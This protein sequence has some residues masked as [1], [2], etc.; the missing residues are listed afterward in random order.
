MTTREHIKNALDASLSTGKYVQLFLSD[1]IDLSINQ[2]ISPDVIL[3][4]I[5]TLENKEKT[6]L[7]NLDLENCPIWLGD[8]ESN[9]KRSPSA[10][11]ES[12]E[13][14]R[15]CLKGLHHKHYYIH[16]D[17]FATVNVKN[18]QR[19]YPNLTKIGAM[20]KRIAE[21][22]LTGEWIIFKKNNGINTY[23]CLAKHTDGDQ[24]IRDRLIRNGIDLD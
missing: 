11:K 7:K 10:T 8:Q 19:T 6:L 1:L 13:F 20:M 12:S 14:T 24:A 4:E 16:Q 3:R 9:L 15:D 2:K 23:L 5:R 17:D 21:G 18:Q 22:K